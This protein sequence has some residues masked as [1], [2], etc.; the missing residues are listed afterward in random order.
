MAKSYQMSNP[1][2]GGRLYRRRYSEDANSREVDCLV[3]ISS[4]SA[5]DLRTRTLIGC[6]TIVVVVKSSFAGMADLSGRTW[7]TVDGVGYPR[8]IS[9]VRDKRVAHMASASTLLGLEYERAAILDYESVVVVVA[10]DSV[11]L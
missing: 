6:S 2:G 8:K 11:L 3:S 7:K 4:K 5:S 1:G 9:K 10:V